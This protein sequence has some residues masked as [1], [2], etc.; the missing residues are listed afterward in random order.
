MEESNDM[1]KLKHLFKRGEKLGFYMDSLKLNFAYINQIGESCMEVA[2][3]LE[4]PKSVSIMQVTMENP[5]WDYKY[6]EQNVV[7]EEFQFIE[8]LCSF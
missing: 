3:P 4:K 5:S 7:V 2:L 8:S 6:A 1:S